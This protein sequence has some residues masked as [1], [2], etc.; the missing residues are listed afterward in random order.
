MIKKKLSTRLNII[1]KYFIFFLLFFAKNNTFSQS[2]LSNNLIPNLVFYDASI[3]NI[4]K[5]TESFELDGDAIILIG[6]IY[7]SANKIILQKKVGLIAAEGN[8]HLINNKQEAIASRIIFDLYTKQIRMD[9]AL[10]ISDPKETDDKFSEVTLGISKAEI[11]YELSKEKRT[12]EIENELKDLREEYSRIQNL[13]KFKKQDVRNNN[14]IINEITAKYARLLARLTRTQFQPNA[15][16]EKL[17]EKDKEKLLDRRLAVEKFKQE[18]PDVAQKVANFSSIDGY[19]KVSASQI[20]QK[21]ND[22][23]ILNNSIITPCN[24]SSFNEPSI[25]GFSSENAKIEMDNYITMTDV[26][27][28]IFSIPIFYSPW[29]KFP[30]KNKRESGF[31]TPSSYTSTNAG[32][33]TLIPY[34]IVLGPYADS[35]IIYEYFTG[36]GS[37][38]SGEFRFQIDR[39]SLFKSE[40]KFIKDKNYVNDYNTNS[41]KI[42]SQIANTTSQDE[43]NTYNSYRG[44]NNENRWYTDS[45][46]NIPVTSSG[47][48]KTNFENVSDNLY[49]SEFSS[50]NSNIN[51]IAAVFGDT[52]SASRRYLNQDFST[53]YYGDNIVMSLKAQTTKDL[54]AANSE[55]TLRKTPKFEFDLLPAK[56]FNTP[57]IFSNNTTFENITRQ[58]NQNYIP[59]P[60]TLFTN[61]ASNPLTGTYDST[62][63]R[64]PND[65]YAQGKRA[66]TSSTLSLPLP[67]NDYFN[68]NISTTAVGTQYY[69]PDSYP[70]SNVQPYKGYLLHKFHLD[71]PLYSNLNYLSD[72]NNIKTNIT[73]NFT[74]FVDF[75]YTPFVTRSSNFP[76]TYQLWYD[77]DKTVSSAIINVGATLSWTIEKEQFV[78]AKN[79]VARL[80]S[81]SEPGVANLDFFNRILEEQKIKITNKSD[82]IYSLSSQNNSNKIF[83]SWAKS[84]LE[85][86]YDKIT[87]NE[88]NQNYIWPAGSFYAKK[89]LLAFT[90]L[91]LSVVTGYNL[92][93]DQTANETNN[94]AGPTVSPVQ[95]QKYTDI[96]ASANLNLNPIIPVQANLGVSYNQFYQ[97]INSFSSN[98][99]VD[100]P[101]GLGLDYTN[102]QQFINNP[103]SNSQDNFIRKTQQAAKLTY[104]PLNWLKLGYQWSE[105]TDPTANTDTSNGKGYGSS[106]SISFTN[107]QNCL[108]VMFARNKQAGIPENMATYVISLTFRF[109]GYSYT[110]SQLGD[111]LDR[112]IKE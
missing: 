82:D 25:Y 59:L 87:V 72:S 99:S 50:N 79:N 26:T 61:L 6:N 70:Y 13:K 33:A 2:F 105:N 98:I 49:L 51:P 63:Q 92:I 19:V 22:T 5:S 15:F 52:S 73:Q 4:N 56:Y 88:L 32:S 48:I 28:D 65:P 41:K 1:Y 77:Q 34:F 7:I 89:T 78:E 23:L 46:V 58:N 86:Y 20:I 37:Q 60:Q 54:F 107:L 18:N 91:S 57:F 27:L 40:G 90:P 96:V 43:I 111:Y 42:D 67:A 29:L 68:S 44:I 95:P 8:V 16:L 75:I 36:R 9:D 11:A 31:L 24:C 94:L 103:N 17:S 39:D 38:F 3:I 64:N 112:K 101:F 102:N 110:S 100:F 97:R 14:D 93:A 10:I 69:F 74:P 66:Y 12:K 71:I 106:Q 62:N 84:E 45:S 47:S 81:A 85:N 83:E 21:N 76:S 108:D 104:T 53:E 55:T 35:T 109:F 30:I 80:P